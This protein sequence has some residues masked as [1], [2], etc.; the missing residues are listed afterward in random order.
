[1]SEF[2]KSFQWTG[3][4]TDII[5]FQSADDSPMC[6]SGA[7]WAWPFFY[8]VVRSGQWVPCETP[9]TAH[10]ELTLLRT[11]RETVIQATQDTPNHRLPQVIFAADDA[12]RKVNQQQES[13]T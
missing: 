8:K 11:F 3:D 2:P 1:M 9:F 4:E 12:V 13:I 10:D 6:K 5:T 7:R